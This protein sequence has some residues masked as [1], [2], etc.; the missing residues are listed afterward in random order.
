MIKINGS[1][2]FKLVPFP[3][4]SKVIE[5]GDYVA[6][7]SKITKTLGW[8]PRTSL[9]DGLKKTLQFYRENKAYYWQ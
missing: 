7:H 6:D 9:E 5:I 2:K 3:P 1:G 4:D 8:E